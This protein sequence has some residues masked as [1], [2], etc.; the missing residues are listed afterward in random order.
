M[1]FCISVNS[2]YEKNYNLL[3]QNNLELIKVLDFIDNVK[4]AFIKG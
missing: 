4:K 3:S 2:F 1:L